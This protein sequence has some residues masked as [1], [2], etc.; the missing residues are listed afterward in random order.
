MMLYIT[1]SEWYIID[2]TQTMDSGDKLTIRAPA[3]TGSLMKDVN[4]N[5]LVGKDFFKQY[6]SDNNVVSI[7]MRQQ[8]GAMYADVKYTLNEFLVRFGF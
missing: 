1:S 5:T 7:F 3:Y 4:G 8:F 2:E 6:C